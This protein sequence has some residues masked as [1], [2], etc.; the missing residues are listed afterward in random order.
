M[1]Q[2]E[3]KTILQTYLEHQ[4]SNQPE[5]GHQKCQ[6]QIRSPVT[7]TNQS[8]ASKKLVEPVEPVTHP[9]D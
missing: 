2:I 6:K 1:A 5:K 7:P 3:P 4:D 9:V 8:T